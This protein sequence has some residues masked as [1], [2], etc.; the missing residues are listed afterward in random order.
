M[1]IQR[2]NISRY[3][4]TITV[5][6]AFIIAGC[7]SNKSPTSPNNNPPAHSTRYHTV[8][9]QNFAFSPASLPIAMGDTVVWTN[10]DSAP[11]T[12]TSNSGTELQSAQFTPG[13]TFQHI[14]PAAGGF[15]YHCIVHP[16]MMGSVTVQ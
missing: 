7:S 13:Q 8:N 5:V 15:A 14:F 4:L 11:H 3:A 12:V 9:I 10:N 6:G 2:I 16:S 1:K